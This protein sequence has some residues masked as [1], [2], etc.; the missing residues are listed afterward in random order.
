MKI[1]KVFISYSHDS[2]NH[3]KWILEL[4]TR[5]R[6]NGIDAIIDQWELQPGDDLPY[7]M[8]TH[9]SDSDKIIMV[10]TEKYVKKANAG[11]GGVGYEKMITNFVLTS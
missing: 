6:N 7:F 5:I 1:P 4:A 2:V 10:C 11:T 3:K 9:L 8:K